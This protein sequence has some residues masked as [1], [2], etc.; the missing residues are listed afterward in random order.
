MNEDLKIIKK[1]Y[2]EKMMHLC[3]EL[4]PTI[5]EEPGL[6]PKLLLANFYPS[7]YLCD[8]IVANGLETDF[9]NAMFAFKDYEEFPEILGV[10]AYDLMRS[11]GYTLYECK[12]E[13]EIQFFKKYYA[14]GEALCTFKGGR[15]KKRSVFFAVKDGAEDLKRSDFKNPQRQDEYGTSVISIQFAKNASMHLTI[16]NRYNHTVLNCDATFSNNLEN[17]V[18]SLTKAFENDYGLIQNYKS[19]N[20][21]LPNYERASDGRFYKYNYEED[22]IY[23]CTDNIIIDNGEVKKFPKEQYIIIEG[24]VLD[25]KNKTIKQYNPKATHDSFLD[26][27]EKIERIEIKKTSEGRIIYITVEGDKTVEV[28]IDH[29]NRIIGYSNSFVRIIDDSFLHKNVVLK[30]LDLANVERIGNDCLPINKDLEEVNLP[31]L[32]RVGNNFL[33]RNK[34]LTS[35]SL[36]L[37]LQVGDNFLTWGVNLKSL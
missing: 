33:A 4:F 24:F 14:F 16:T 23:Y 18:P 9:K 19:T 34:G 6:L 35:I 17:I 8:D 3:R 27:F 15:L 5:L 12:T 25:L 29:Q 11:V 28:S 36:P 1:K 22:D 20:F 30:K 21:D 13:E 10:S 7:V 2:G 37:L 32:W 26:F 31:K